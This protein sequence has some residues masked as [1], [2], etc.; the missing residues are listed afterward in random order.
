MAGLVVVGLIVPSLVCA[1]VVY[2]GLVRLRNRIDNRLPAYPGGVVARDGNFNP[3]GTDE[4]RRDPV[5]V[6]F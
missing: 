1:V 4:G 3:R 5:Q 6:Q 2:N